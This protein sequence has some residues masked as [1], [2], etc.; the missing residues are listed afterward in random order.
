MSRPPDI[1]AVDLKRR[2]AL[3]D[4][5]TEL[6]ITNM[7]TLGGEE[8]DDPDLC[9]RVVVKVRDDCWLGAVVEAETMN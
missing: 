4:D 8:T 1:E 6:P 3:M 2:V 9:R 5:D 7:L